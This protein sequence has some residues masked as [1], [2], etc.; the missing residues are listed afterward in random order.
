M[1]ITSEAADGRCVSA[2]WR[3]GRRGILGSGVFPSATGTA[4]LDSFCLDST[5][6]QRSAPSDC[7]VPRLQP[8]EAEMEA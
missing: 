6:P 7:G 3:P 5:A 1:I 2:L 8:P 4:E